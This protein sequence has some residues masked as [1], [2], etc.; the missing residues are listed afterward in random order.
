MN[1]NMLGTMRWL[2]VYQVADNDLRSS[3]DGQVQGGLLGCVLNPGVDVSLDANEEQDTL[4]VRVLHSHVEEVTS[5]VVHL[6]INRSLR[7]GK[8]NIVWP[9]VHLV[10]FSSRKASIS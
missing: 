8:K 5:L 9:C 2:G 10:S 6:V 1:G 7:S 4:D 3:M